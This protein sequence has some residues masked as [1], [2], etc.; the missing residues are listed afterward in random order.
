MLPK[1]RLAIFVN[2]CFW[3]GHDCSDGH[4]PKTNVSYWAP[5]IAGNVA[6]D[7]LRH[8]QLTRAGWQVEVIHECMCRLETDRVVSGLSQLRDATGHGP[9]AGT[10]Q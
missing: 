5:K 1:Y 6:R 2:G 8:Q 3:H 10:S 9:D 4:V 7:E